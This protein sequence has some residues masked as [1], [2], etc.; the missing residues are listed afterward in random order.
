MDSWHFMRRIAK[1]CSNESHPLY[2]PFMQKVSSA[3]FEWDLADV[4]TLRTAKEGELKKAG[5]S[6]P[7]TAAVNKA[8]T[9]F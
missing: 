2:C 3:I 9:K 6:K 8:I 1:A 5:V 7:S 4:A